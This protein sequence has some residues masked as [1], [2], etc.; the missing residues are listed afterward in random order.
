MGMEG[1]EEK[2]ETERKDGNGHVDK[3]DKGKGKQRAE[4]RNADGRKDGD[5]GGNGNR[6]A[7]GE[8][9]Q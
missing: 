4:D 3:Q 6:E 8:T 5:E 9:L 7:N 1:S 2:E